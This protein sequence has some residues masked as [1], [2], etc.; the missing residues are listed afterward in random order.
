MMIRGNILTLRPSGSP[1]TPRNVG[2]PLSA[3][4]PAPVRTTSLS[5]GEMESTYQSRLHVGRIPSW[6]DSR[7]LWHGRQLPFE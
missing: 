2:I 7:G 1:P 6:V 3:P 4:T 5:V